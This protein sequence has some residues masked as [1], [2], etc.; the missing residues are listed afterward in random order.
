M[1]TPPESLETIQRGAR[2]SVTGVPF[3]AGRSEAT[4]IPSLFVVE[5]HTYSAPAPLALD[6][7]GLQREATPRLIIGQ[8]MSLLSEYLEGDGYVRYEPRYITSSPVGLDTEPLVVRFPGR[9]SDLFL[10]IT[11]LPQLLYAAIMTG[12]RKLYSPT[13]LFSRAYRDGFTSA[14]SPIIALVETETGGNLKS[15]LEDLV[16]FVVSGLNKAEQRGL[17]LDPV[18]KDDIVVEKEAASTVPAN[19]V[20]LRLWDTPSPV[21]TQYAYD[22]RRRVE[23]ETAIGQVVIEGHEGRIAQTISYNWLCV[24]VERLAMADFWRIGRRRGPTS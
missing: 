21:T 16:R 2:V 9:G 17:P 10:E 15:G 13:R 22:V 8:L 23:L 1:K 4:A 11:P 24:H 18:P 5:L 6:E 3:L 14:E 19:S 7:T 12:E 20:V